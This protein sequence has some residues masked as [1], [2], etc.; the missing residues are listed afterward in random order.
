[1]AS[2]NTSNITNVTRRVTGQS[3]TSLNLGLQPAAIFRIAAGQAPG[4]TAVVQDPNIPWIQSV[5]GPGTNDIGTNTTG[6]SAV[7]VTLGAVTGTAITS[8]IGTTDW[9][10]FGP[11]P[12]S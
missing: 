5:I 1:M 8:T 3:C 9:I 2:V 12:T 10:V 6:V 7:T 4:D 11:L